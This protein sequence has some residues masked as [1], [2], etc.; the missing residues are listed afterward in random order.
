MSDVRKPAEPIGESGDDPDDLLSKPIY[1]WLSVFG[2]VIALGSLTSVIFFLILEFVSRVGTGYSGLALL[3]PIGIAVIGSVM[4]LVGYVRERWRQKRGL[5][6]S[7]HRRWVIEPS[8]LIRGVSPFVIGSG[9]V[10]TTLLLLGGGA[11]SLTLVE[12]TESNAFC[13][14]SCHQVMSPE[15]EVYATSP[16]SG[17][18]CV[19]CHVGS[20]GGSYVKAKLNGLR[21]VYALATGDF[22]RPIPTPIHSRPSTSDMCESCHAMDHL[23]EYKAISRSYFLSNEENQ[24]VKLR[25]MMKIGS[26]TDGPMKGAGIHYHMLVA[27]RVEFIARDP[28]RQDIAWVRVTDENGEIRAHS[29]AADPLSAAERE[30][31]EVHTLDC[32][33]CHSRP[34]HR[35]PSPVESVNAA[36]STGRISASRAMTAAALM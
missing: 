3:P 26:G 4:M 19:V 25:M 23:D 32:L 16:H 34:A 35:F 2:G 11:G 6:S 33:D 24:Q 13:G 5:H 17:I 31:F 20:G 10:I 15:A 27:N 12:Y 14:E 36:L 30:A 29:H 28:Q 1:N 8:S 9:V 21:Q 22:Q 18:A 7:F